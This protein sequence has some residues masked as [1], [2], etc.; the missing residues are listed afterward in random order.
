MA[1]RKFQTITDLHRTAH[2]LRW[3]FPILRRVAPRLPDHLDLREPVVALERGIRLRARA[4]W[5]PR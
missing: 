3:P 1:G 2:V 4:R 5:V